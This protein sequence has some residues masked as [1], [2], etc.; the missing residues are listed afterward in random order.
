MK[1]LSVVLWFVC[2]V[3]FT[4]PALAQDAAGAETPLATFGDETGLFTMQYPADLFVASASFLESRGLP[5]PSVAISSSLDIFLRP[6]APPYTPIAMGD[7]GIAV[8]FFPKAMFAPMGIAADAPIL[9][10]ANAWAQMSLTG[11]FTFQPDSV[12]LDSGAEAIVITGR[13]EDDGAGGPPP[14]DNYLMLHEIANGVIVLTTIVSAV[15]GRTTEMEALHLALTNSI[16]FTGTVEDILAMMPPPQSE[17]HQFTITSSA[18][19]LTAPET[20]P[21]GLVTVAFENSAETPFVGIFGRLNEGATMEDLMT[22]M[23]ENP[24]ALASQLTLKGGPGVMPGQT[25][26]MTY[27]LDAGNYVLLNVGAQPPQIASISVAD[28]EDV[29]YEEPIADVTVTLAD[30]A[31]GIPL[32]L[33]AG[34]HLWQIDNVGE[35]WHEIVIA[36]VEPDATL[37]ELQA[38]MA[39]GEQSGLQLFPLAMPLS[40]GQ[41]A[42]LTVDLQ[43]GTYLIVCSLPDILR[44]EE[45]HSHLELGMV[46]LVTVE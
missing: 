32:T 36:P 3:I 15:D 18:D 37:E 30:F 26:E 16:E 6:P 24:M 17:A 40:G 45:M 38:L 23:A 9:D 2:L 31:F 12:I 34:K 14:E 42:W 27:H 39:E 8:I 20:L 33:P 5:F 28:G 46:Q 43:P 22:A 41:S 11:S 29:E 10:V 21:E 25:T 19:G 13:G 7:W 44:M 4:M 35:Q 1:K